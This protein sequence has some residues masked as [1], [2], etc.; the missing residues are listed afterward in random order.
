VQDAVLDV[1]MEALYGDGTGTDHVYAAT[2]KYNGTENAA[3]TTAAVQ[4]Y[5]YR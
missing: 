5:D 2:D 1:S 3:V 4:L